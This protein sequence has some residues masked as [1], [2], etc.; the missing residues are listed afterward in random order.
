MCLFP[1]SRNWKLHFNEHES[2]KSV[3]LCQH[4][5]L[6]TGKHAAATFSGLISPAFSIQSQDFRP[7]TKGWRYHYKNWI[8]PTMQCVHKCWPFCSEYSLALGWVFLCDIAYACDAF[9]NTCLLT[10]GIWWKNFLVPSSSP[11]LK[12]EKLS[13]PGKTV[14]RAPRILEKIWEIINRSENDIKTCFAA[15]HFVFLKQ[16]WD[17]YLRLVKTQNRYRIPNRDIW[18]S[19]QV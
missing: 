14:E 19:Q 7:H 11:R 4:K 18:S 15:W 16:N 12:N 8:F 17:D 10:I 3:P 9:E 5:T 13:R 6:E 2:E 1:I